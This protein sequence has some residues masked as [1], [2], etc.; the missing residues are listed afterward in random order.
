MSDQNVSNSKNL[1]D[2]STFKQNLHED[3]LEA[4]ELE[5]LSLESW[6][7]RMD[8]VLKLFDRWVDQFEENLDGACPDPSKSSELANLVT[9]MRRLLEIKQI[10]QK[11]RAMEE[12][13]TNDKKEGTETDDILDPELFGRG[14]SQSSD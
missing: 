2:N 4:A 9:M 6:R 3:D 14:V 12:E 5:S 1:P 8:R 13:N 7:F 10:E 11:L